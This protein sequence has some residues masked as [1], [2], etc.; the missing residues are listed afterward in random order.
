MPSIDVDVD[1]F[2]RENQAEL[3]SF[4]RHRLAQS[5]DAVDLAQESWS[6]LMRYR[7]DQPPASLRGLLF[8]IARNVL[9]NHWRWNSLHQLEQS[10]DFT[11]LDVVSEVPGVE[12]QWQARRCLKALEEAVAD[13]PD[14]RRTVFLLSRV[15]GLSNAQVA[16]RCGISVK[17]VEKHL[18]KA[19]V[20]CR[21]QVGDF[22]P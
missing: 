14:K 10:T 5:Q 2:V 12:R 15:E 18:A 8:T 20:Q 7:H 4:F 21:A 13:M 11:G 22:G 3:L 19:I 9:N 16:Q 1:V 17:M 6:R